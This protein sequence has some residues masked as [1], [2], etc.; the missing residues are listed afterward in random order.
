MC[1]RNTYYMIQ[2]RI[3]CLC[4]H[5]PMITK[6]RG[7]E[8]YKEEM[9]TRLSA[10]L[11]KRIKKTSTP[12]SIL[13]ESTGNYINAIGGII[14]AIALLIPTT[15]LP[16]LLLLALPSEAYLIDWIYSQLRPSG[17]ISYSDYSK[18]E[19]NTSWTE[20][21]RSSSAWGIFSKFAR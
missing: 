19:S 9:N 11:D 15:W 10:G 16:G 12:Y 1:N 2:Y 14:L 4:N 17:E 7:L 18:E 20:S 13:S 8:M 21:E 6:D 3:K 5:G